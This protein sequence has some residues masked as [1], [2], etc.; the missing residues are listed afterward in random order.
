MC[1]TPEE[2]L[3]DHL[4]RRCPGDLEGDLRA[5]YSAQLLVL[6]KDGVFRGKKGIRHT[7][8]I[9]ASNLPEAQVARDQLQVADGM[10]LLS[11]S[12]CASNRAGTC[13]GADTFVIEDGKIVARTIPYKVCQPWLCGRLCSLRPNTVPV[14]GPWIPGPG[15]VPARETGHRCLELS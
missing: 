6:W 7:A 13:H 9:W 8:P 5:N 12:A 11:G 4:D 2:V 1:R 14:P 10:A 15:G 3:Q